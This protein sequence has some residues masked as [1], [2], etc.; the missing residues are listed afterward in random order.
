MFDSWVT[1]Q[2]SMVDRPIPEV[3]QIFYFI[4]HYCRIAFIS[5][6]DNDTVNYI[7]L[8]TKNKSVWFNVMLIRFLVIVVEKVVDVQVCVV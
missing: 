2:R 1:L 3:G 4:Q 7:C 6:N 8:E 5:W